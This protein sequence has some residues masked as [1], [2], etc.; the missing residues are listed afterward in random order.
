MCNNN[1]T[2]D[3]VYIVLSSWHGHWPLL[4]FTRFIQW[5]QVRRQ[6]A[7]SDPANWLRLWV[8]L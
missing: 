6:A 5:M 8:H 1:N 2:N 3:N 4:E 7:A